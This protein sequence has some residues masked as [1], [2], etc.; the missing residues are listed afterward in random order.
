MYIHL[1]TNTFQ[2]LTWHWIRRI[3][4]PPAPQRAETALAV[5]VMQARIALFLRFRRVNAVI[6]RYD[7]RIRLIQ[8]LTAQPELV[9]ASVHGEAEAL[10]RCFAPHAPASFLETGA[11]VGAL[12]ARRGALP[13]RHGGVGDLADAGAADFFNPPFWRNKRGSIYV[14]LFALYKVCCLHFKGNIS[15]Q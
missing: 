6:L 14:K 10:L 5:P 11:A 2:Q 9:L 15:N 12:V 1:K 3:I 4:T 7:E 8:P 13:E